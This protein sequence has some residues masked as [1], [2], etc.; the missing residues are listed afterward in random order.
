[1]RGDF[2]AFS[3]SNTGYSYSFQLKRDSGGDQTFKS[4]I[5]FMSDGGSNTQQHTFDSNSD[6]VYFSGDDNLF[7]TVTKTSYSNGQ[8]Y[9]IYEIEIEGPYSDTSYI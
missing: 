2:Q 5:G 3:S 6:L 1:M 9:F 7:F 8:Y 4:G